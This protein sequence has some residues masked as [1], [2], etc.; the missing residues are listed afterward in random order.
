MRKLIIS[1]WDKYNRL[2]IIKEVQGVNNKK[3]KFQCKCDCW[4]I[5]DIDLENLKSWHTRSC[6][7][8]SKEKNI[9]WG[10]NHKTHWMHWTKIYNIWAWLKKRCNNIDYRDYKYYGWRWITY[11]KK[12]EKFEWFYKDMKEW[13]SVKLSI[14]RIDNNWNYSKENCRWAT[15]IQQ[16]RNKRNN[17]LYKWKCISQWC[18]E[19]WINRHTF[20]SR[21][22]YGWT[23][24]KALFTPI[25]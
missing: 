2:T 10:I 24:E 14:D 11:D 3:R 22:R 4:N 6:W 8:I 21:L 13:Y 18:E 5:K 20:T 1:K 12:W 16:A 9:V 15:D 17:V 19:L 25:Q 7:C 23:I